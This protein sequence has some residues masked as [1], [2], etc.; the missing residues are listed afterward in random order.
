MENRDS[1]P[2]PPA[3]SYAPATR[4][5]KG[6]AVPAGGD[7]A[8]TKLTSSSGSS[9]S[10]TL[11]PPRFMQEL[12]AAV[13]RQRPFGPMQSKLPRATRVLVSGGECGNK[14]GASASV[15]KHPEQKVTQTQRGLLV[16]SRLPN[17]TPDQST[18]KLG[19]STPDELMLT[20]SSSVLKGTIDTHAQSVGQ[21]NNEA[22]LLI[23]TEKSALEALPSQTTS[24]NALIGE[25]FKKGQLD[26]DGN[27]QLTS[28]RD[29]FPANQGAQYDHQQNHQEL[30]IVGAPNLSRRGIDEA[31][32]HNHGEPMT[33]FSAIGSSVTAISLHSGPTV[34]SS[35]TPQVSRYTSPVQ[36]PESAVESSKGVLGH[37]SQKE[38]GGATGVGDWNPHNQQVQNLGNGATDKAVSSIGRLRSEGLL[39]NDQSTSAR[40]GGASQPN[41]GQKERHKKNYDPNVFFK[42]NG[43]LY[44]KLGKIG[45]GG[46]SEVHKVISSDCIIYAL[47]KIKLRGRD[48]PTAY[49]FCQEIEYLNKLKGKS[50]IIQ[51]IDYEVTDKSLL[52]ESS[53]PPRDGRIKDDHFI[54]MVLEYGEIDL[55]NMVALKWKER[56][57]CNM[58]ID[59][60]WLR[61][62]WQQMLEA[63]STIHEERIVHSDLKP[64]NFMLVRGSLKLIDFGIAKAIMNDTTNIQRDAQVGTLN[65]MSP[66]AFMCNDTDSGGNVIKCGRPSDIWSLGCILYQMVYGKTPFADY[67]TFWAKY[68]EVT[69]RN[70]KIMYEPVDNPWLIDLMQRCLAWD[71]N[72]RWRIPQLLKHPFLN[73]PV[74]KDLP[75]SDNDPCR[76]LMERIRVHWDNP[77]VQKFHSLIQELDG[78]Q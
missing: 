23:D 24:C 49:G 39:A 14:V 13:K 52:L 66:E 64:A 8:A 73:P 77:V 27:P 47:K 56:H 12:H 9:S 43:K 76:L 4:A 3:P 35:Q 53:V 11:S 69:D 15:A 57:N 5:V 16:P 32:N 46:S 67:K 26:L 48:Y 65:Y 22:N 62:Y 78:D 31:R 63:V 21:K 58:K 51:M 7:T 29:N 72:E 36:M 41:K 17:A 45:S 54:Y 19:S 25:S 68:K 20:S 38:H 1:F 18:P 30:E 2:R 40:D 70:H 6:I 75:P 71:R 74:P 33:R 60:N 10:L 34:Q 55:A 61:F 50:N 44:Q 28:Q 42:V 37:G 59:E